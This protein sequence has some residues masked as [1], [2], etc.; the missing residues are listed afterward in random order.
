MKLEELQPLNGQK[1]FYRKAFVVVE[2]DPETFTEIYTLFSYDTEICRI[3]Y[4]K[5]F[6]KNVITSR[7]PLATLSRTSRKHLKAFI[8]TYS[9]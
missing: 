4:S 8:D 3:E 6:G 5:L 1:S 2:E 9:C 7:K